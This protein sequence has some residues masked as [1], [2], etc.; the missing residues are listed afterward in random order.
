MLWGA[1]GVIG[2]L[3]VKLVLKVADG[4]IFIVGVVEF[5][6]VGVPVGMN[7]VES[8]VS[9]VGQV[10]GMWSVSVIQETGSP[11]ES[12][13][14]SGHGNVLLCVVGNV[15]EEVMEILWCACE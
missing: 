5:C 12:V 3:C 9:V 1:K 8:A 7:S 13:K 4:I 6:M 14:G 10:N 15:L 11:G 2:G